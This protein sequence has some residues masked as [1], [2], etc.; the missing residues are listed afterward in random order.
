MSNEI[1]S[2]KDLIIWQKAIDLVVEIYQVLKS[3]P[4]EEL[5][6]LSDQIKRS[7]VSVPSNIAEGQSRQ[8]TAEFRQFLYIAM[9]SLAELDTQL[10]IAH[11]LGYIDSKNNEF[12]TAR[13]IELRKMVSALISK[14][15]N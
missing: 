7:A 3:F 8:H 10:I 11:R 12:F 15:K 4:R 5:Y 14:L 6:G 9:G 1:R 2:Y 13:V